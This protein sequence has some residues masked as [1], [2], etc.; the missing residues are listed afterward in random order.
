MQEW[1]HQLTQVEAK[2]AALPPQIESLVE[3]Q[4]NKLEIAA[5]KKR[6]VLIVADY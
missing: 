4:Q 3:Q 1:Q 5:L 6:G 2:L